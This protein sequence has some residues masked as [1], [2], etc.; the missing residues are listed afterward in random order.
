MKRYNIVYCQNTSTKNGIEPSQTSNKLTNCG[1]CDAS[2]GLWVQEEANT[3]TVTA[4]HAG[5]YKTTTV[6]CNLKK[7]SSQLF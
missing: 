5:K 2:V 3:L 4:N 6:M 1:G 7:F